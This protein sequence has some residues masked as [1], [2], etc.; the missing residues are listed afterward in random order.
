MLYNFNDIQNAFVDGRINFEQ[1]FEILK[2]NFGVVKAR[3]II[4]KNIKMALRQ[5]RKNRKI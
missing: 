1:L 4:K 2:D 5:E 3:K